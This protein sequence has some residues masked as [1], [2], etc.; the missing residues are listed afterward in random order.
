MASVSSFFCCNV[1]LSSQLMKVFKGM[2]WGQLWKVKESNSA[3]TISKLNKTPKVYALC[4]DFLDQ[5]IVK[6]LVIYFVPM[7]T[8]FSFQHHYFLHK[9]NAR[10]GIKE[11]LT[12]KL[13]WSLYLLLNS[14][15]WRFTMS[16]FVFNT[17]PFTFIILG[18]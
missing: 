9:Y 6:I 7:K 18:D 10:V 16:S 14:L 11:P 17:H 2:W 4:R 15:I 8:H 3:A 1:S 12:W 13:M 5:F